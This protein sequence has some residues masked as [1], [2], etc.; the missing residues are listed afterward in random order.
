[1]IVDD[2]NGI[3]SALPPTDCRSASRCTTS[4]VASSS[5]ASTSGRRSSGLAPR[6][7]SPTSHH[8]TLGLLAERDRLQ[9]AIDDWHAANPTPARGAYRA[10]LERIGYIVPE[11]G[12]GADRDE[13]TSIPEIASIAGPQ[14]VVPVTNARYALN[15]ANARWGSLYDALYGTDALG[16]LPPAAPTTPCGATAVI[17]WVRRF[18]DDVVPLARQ[19]PRRRGRATR[20]STGVSSRTAATP[21][22]VDWASHGSGSTPTSGRARRRPARSSCGTTASASSSWSTASTRSGRTDRA[23]V[24]DVRLE[25]AVTAIMDC[26]DSVAAVDAADKALAYR[27]WLGLMQGDLTAAVD[28]GRC[29]VQARDWTAI[30]RHAARRVHGRRRGPRSLMLVRNVGHLMT[31]PAVLDADGTEVP[32]GML[33][34]IF[35]VAVRDARPAPAP[36]H[37]QLAGRVGLRREA[38]DARTGRGRLR[39]RPLRVGRGHARPAPQ[40]GEARDHGRGA[41]HDASTSASASVPRTS[42]VAFINTGFLDRTG[43]EIHTSMQAG[44]M[45]RKAT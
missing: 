8:A 38:E 27:N 9:A 41:A 33:D 24:A 5:A 3:D 39:R 11:R 22:A 25:A 14:L 4:W 44:P 17:A 45:V 19:P 35:T 10:F 34:A 31:T 12:A 21:A 13:P 23:G 16:D 40:H 1:M 2:I 20:S 37:T 30:A 42:R 36:D 32:E 28:E 7:S 15:A 29:D 18:L 6:R 26:E 43:D